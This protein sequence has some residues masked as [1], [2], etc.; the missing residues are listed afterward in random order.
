M[1]SPLG[2]HFSD[3]VK[4]LNIRYELVSTTVAWASFGKET[5]EIGLGICAG[6]CRL[7]DRS[8]AVDNL[9]YTR[10]PLPSTVIGGQIACGGYQFSSYEWGSI[11]TIHEALHKVLLTK[12]CDRSA[13]RVFGSSLSS[14]QSS[15]NSL[16]K[17]EAVTIR[18]RF[19]IQPG[20]QSA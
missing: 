18:T 15:I 19:S 6:L 9:T 10:C 12:T 20:R 4:E 17:K 1:Y 2:S 3:W 16:T 14:R 13:L 11:F 5:H 7:S 8:A